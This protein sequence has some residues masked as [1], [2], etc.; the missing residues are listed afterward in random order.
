[1]N[2]KG[3]LSQVQQSGNHFNESATLLR[4]T[5][6]HR[7]EVRIAIEKGTVL[8]QDDGTVRKLLHVFGVTLEPKVKLVQPGYQF[9]L[10]F[11]GLSQD[12]A[13]FHL[14][15]PGDVETRIIVRYIQRR[16]SGVY[17]VEIDETPFYELY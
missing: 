17:K 7:K 13:F 12:C 5:V 3:S 6:A 2:K 16:S 15:E 11:E 1:M 8:L 10:V 9:Y 4:C 14:F